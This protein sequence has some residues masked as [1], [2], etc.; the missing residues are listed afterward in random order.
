MKGIF[1]DTACD[2]T[3]ALPQ[4]QSNALRS[5]EMGVTHDWQWS[6]SRLGET[7]NL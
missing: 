5:G 1:E 2:K 7:R 3:P 4:T 6:H